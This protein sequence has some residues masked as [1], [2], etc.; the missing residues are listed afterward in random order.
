[1][2]DSY[3]LQRFLDAQDGAIASDLAT[4]E[5]ALSELRAGRKMG[6]WIWFVFPQMDLGM[7]YMA[8]KY[9]IASLDEA[10]AYLNH[11]VLGRRLV[12]CC[13]ALLALTTSDPRSVLGSTD[14]MKLRSSMTLF[15]RADAEVEVFRAVL[16]RFFGG[17]PDPLTLELLAAER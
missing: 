2:T 8:H 15:A 5:G 12:Q 10:R 4:Y 7:S 1:L 14:S 11:P 3:D 16:G 6:H 13:E 17:E 9:A